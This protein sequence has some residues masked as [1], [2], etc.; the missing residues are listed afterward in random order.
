MPSKAEQLQN[1]GQLTLLMSVELRLDAARRDLEALQ[2][3]AHCTVHTQSALDRCE[4]DVVT[5]AQYDT[6]NQHTPSAQVCHR[7]DSLTQ[8]S[9]VCQFEAGLSS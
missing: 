5:K 7:S 3:S 8:Q 6:A 9:G 2:Q 1:V 4:S